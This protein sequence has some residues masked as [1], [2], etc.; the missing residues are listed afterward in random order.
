MSYQIRVYRGRT[1][2]EAA[3]KCMVPA[4]FTAVGSPQ[5][6]TALN[7]Q[8][9]VQGYVD[10]ADIADVVSGAQQIKAE[11]IASNEAL[12]AIGDA[13]LVM[14][15]D[16][17]GLKSGVQKAQ[18]TADK[19]HSVLVGVAASLTTLAAALPGIIALLQQI[20]TPGNS[21]PK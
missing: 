9:I 17:A 18:V 1:I 3:A 14:A 5:I 4:G 20:A 16:A 2:E 8:L 7:E 6:I 10:S 21:K 19:I 15:G 12:A 13:V 11:L